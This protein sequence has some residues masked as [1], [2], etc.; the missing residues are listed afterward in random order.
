MIP[1][2]IIAAHLSVLFLV[3]VLTG[4]VRFGED[5]YYKGAPIALFRIDNMYSLHLKG[6]GGITFMTWFAII[7]TT[8][9]GDT[10]TRL[11]G[12]ENPNPKLDP[13]PIPNKV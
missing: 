2:L 6:I 8:A 4:F 9:D 10:A 12:W 1:T 13:A 7:F 11:Y 3:A 5:A